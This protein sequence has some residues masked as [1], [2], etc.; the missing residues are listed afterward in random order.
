MTRRSSLVALLLALASCAAPALHTQPGSG[1][2]VHV[3]AFWLKPGAPADVVA[4]MRDCYLNRVAR[5]VP[6]VEAAWVGKPQGSERSVV[7][8]SFS[9][10][11]VV[12]FT[13]AAAE[14]RWQT[15]PVH[16]ELK[17]VFEPHLDRVVVYDFVE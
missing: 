7:D 16:D 4:K 14:A 6:G 5:E 15:H 12:R 11:S 8:D 17:R 2:L 1:K 13:D 9:C 3:V 10:M